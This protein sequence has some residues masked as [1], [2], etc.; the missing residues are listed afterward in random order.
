MKCFCLGLFITALMGLVGCSEC[1]KPIA[2][3][4]VTLER[5]TFAE[6]VEKVAAQ[7]DKVVVVDVWGEFCPP[8]KKK[9][10]HLVKIAKEFAGP[11]FV[12][13]SLSLDEV[14]NEG[15]V[16]QFLVQEKAI[17]ANFILVDTD[18]NKF[19]GNET[20]EIGV[21]PLLHVFDRTGKLVKTFDN[22]NS[23]DEV[24]QFIRQLIDKK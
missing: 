10:P 8:C 20:I 4:D 5:V 17:F 11:D 13:M 12:A 23:N 1:Q 16:M 24:D 18:D 2:K 3:P 6:F 21:P 22:K 9:F 7:K 14:D 19:K 15:A